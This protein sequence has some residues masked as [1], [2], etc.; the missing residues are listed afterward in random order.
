MRRFNVLTSIFLG[1]AALVGSAEGGLA[2][3]RVALVIGNYSYR[4]VE[5]L[6][7]PKN[8][9]PAIAKM[10][11]DMG[12]DQV[13]LVTD[14]GNLE[15]K[16]AI[17]HFGDVS[18]NADVAVVY[19]AGHAIEVG[20][21]AHSPFAA[22]LLRHLPEPVE[23][24]RFAFGRIRDDVLKATDKRQRPF[25][26]GSLGGDRISLV[27]GQVADVKGDYDRADKVGTRRAFQIFLARYPT[28]YYAD[29]AR[30]ALGKL[31]PPAPPASDDMTAWEKIKD[32]GDQAALRNFIKRFSDSP[33]A[34]NAEHRLQVLADGEVTR[35]WERVDKDNAAAIQKF[36]KAFPASSLAAGT[37][38]AR[39]NEL[40]QLAKDREAKKQ[41]E[42]AAA[43]KLEVER[44]AAQAWQKIKN[45]SDR[46]A[47]LDFVNRYPD[48]P[49]LAEAQQRLVVIDQEERER[50]AKQE[51]EAA[52]AKKQQLEREVAQE[53]E[54]IKS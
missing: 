4:N 37:A 38:K 44:Q 9:A 10:F 22:A 29:L 53:W 19:Y 25:V 1:G 32:T 45:T 24:I 26:Y 51:A 2:D 14:V 41:A 23:D 13:D 35:A 31:P 7:N 16:R 52:E 30:E 12:F 36:M 33:L 15:F 5:Q 34:T 11:K 50:K 21:D 40:D 48:S 6:L 47:V 28:G 42:I 43:K 17:R 8:D 54:K 27:P 20:G 39:L 18:A 3:K 46:N 49:L